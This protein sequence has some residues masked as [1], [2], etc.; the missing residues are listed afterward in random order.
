[1]SGRECI[2]SGKDT[3]SL[4][5]WRSC[6]CK[7]RHPVR[8]CCFYYKRVL[9]YSGLNNCASFDGDDTVVRIVGGLYHVLS[10]ISCVS[11]L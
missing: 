7:L 2:E 11:R 5:S 8:E 1:M 3:S 4:A 9:L 6:D 10:F